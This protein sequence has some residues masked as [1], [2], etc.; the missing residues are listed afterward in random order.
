MTIIGSLCCPGI[1]IVFI[2]LSIYDKGYLPSIIKLLGVII[3][4]YKLYKGQREIESEIVQNI[5]KL[6]TGL[7][8]A[9][10]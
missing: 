10:A 5:D 7:E 6:K 1:G 9:N 2:G 4:V 8:V 3:F